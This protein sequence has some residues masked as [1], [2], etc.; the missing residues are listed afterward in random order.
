MTTFRIHFQDGRK[1]DVQAPNAVA[2]R[3]L[4]SVKDSGAVIKI[5]V[6][7]ETANG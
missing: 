4:P 5:K 2:A 1:I 6:V 3:K 7:K